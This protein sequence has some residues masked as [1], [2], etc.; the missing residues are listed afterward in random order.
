MFWAI[1]YENRTRVKR[2]DCTWKRHMSNSRIHTSTKVFKLR[3]HQLGESQLTYQVFYMKRTRIIDIRLSVWR[4]SM[5]QKLNKKCTFEWIHYATRWIIVLN[6]KKKSLL[7]FIISVANLFTHYIIHKYYF[8]V[9]FCNEIKNTFY[10]I[11]SA[12]SVLNQKYVKRY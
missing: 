5:L 3:K 2:L 6:C 11:D 1:I 8:S 10:Y 12:P 4:T 9:L 7:V